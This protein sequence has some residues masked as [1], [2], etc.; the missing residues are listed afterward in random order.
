MASYT[1]ID[2]A[3]RIGGSTSFASVVPSFPLCSMPTAIG[4]LVIWKRD[5]VV[6]WPLVKLGLLTKIFLMKQLF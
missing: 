4:Y 5:E 3:I 1:G 2:S 6:M